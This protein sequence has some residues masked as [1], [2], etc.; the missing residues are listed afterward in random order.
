MT[1]IRTI[2]FNQILP[3]WHRLWEGRKS[4]IQPVTPMIFGGGHDLSIEKSTPTFFGIFDGQQLVAVNSGF[5]TSETQYRH[6][7]LYVL[8]SHRRKGYAKAL[9]QRV[10]EQARK[11]GCRMVWSLPRPG[12]S[13]RCHTSLGF[14]Q[15]SAWF[16][17]N[18]EFGP[19]C[20]MEKKL[21]FDYT[22]KNH[23]RFGYDGQW[24]ATPTNKHQS[25]Q[26]S[27]GRC[28]QTPLR[29]DLECRR[30]ARLLCENTPELVPNLAFSGGIDSEVM[31]R[32]FMAESLPF[33]ITI[34]KF[35]NNLNLHDISFAISFCE[36]HNL[37]YKIQHMD[38]EAFW[39]SDQFHSLANEV[40]CVSPQLLAHL[41][42]FGKADELLVL[43]QGEGCVVNPVAYEETREQFKHS[44]SRWFTI[45]TE[46]NIAMYRYFIQRGK[47][48]I[49]AF[50][51]YTPELMYAF[52]AD[53]TVL[54]MTA[55]KLPGHDSTQTI[56]FEIYKKYFPDLRPRPK[57]S[58]FE[59]IIDQDQPLRQ[60]L[61]QRLSKYTR[62][63]FVEH[64]EMLKRLRPE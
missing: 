2:T 49:P 4:P 32:S 26:V 35:A 47:K 53:P 23:F 58:G 19:N 38:V 63:V 16:T 22:Y 25:W 17:E 51:R 44:T 59:K 20:Y 27:V 1:E 41:N 14:T 30:A 3:M 60:L 28:T 37:D 8:E 29:F 45:E 56:K 6:R 36:E 50:F 5:K 18:M 9:L 11:E 57:F 48:A 15:T 31:L 40:K 55:D 64:K 34:F 24:F 33:N 12:G 13:F 42:Y 43:G 61:T 10:I 21:M 46:K 39:K 52:Y 54:E 62:Q 7:G